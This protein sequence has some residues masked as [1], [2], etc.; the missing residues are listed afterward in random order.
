MGTV[1]RTPRRKYHGL[2]TV[3]E[4]RVGPP[5][6]VIA[7]VGE[8]VV[9]DGGAYVLHSLRLGEKQ[10]PDGGRHLAGFDASP[11]WLYELDGLEV[12]RRVV[13]H[14]DVDGVEV[15]YR[16]RGS[17]GPV[18]LALRPLLRMRPLHDL[19]VANPFLDGELRAAGDH[20]VL[21]LYRD[22][23]PVY[24]SLRGH[25]AELVRDGAWIEGVTYAQEKARGYPFREDLYAPGEY[26]VQ[27]DGPAEL[28]LWI[29]T[30]PRPTAVPV[31]PSPPPEDFVAALDRAAE[32]YT[33]R[34]HT[35]GPTVIAGYPWFGEWSRDALISLPGL[36]LARGRV[37]EATELLE[38]MGS[39]RVD[40]LIPN[41]PGTEA[42]AANRDS[43]DASVLYVHALR[44]VREAA[45][46][47][48]DASLAGRAR[49]LLPIA[50]EI[51]EALADGA[52]RRV[53]LSVDGGLFVERGGWA[54]TWMDAVVDGVPVTPRAGFAVDLDALWLEGLATVLPYAR[55]HL[56][57][58]ASRFGPVLDR[59]IE[60][61][62]PRFWLEEEGYLADCHDGHGP[63]RSLR[64]NQCWALASQLP[65]LS[66][67]RSVRALTAIRR[68]LLTPVGLRTLSADDPSYV[69][70]YEGDQRTRDR[71]YHQGTV[72]PWLL[73]PYADA[74]VAVH[75]LD[76][77]RDEL[78]PALARLE[79]HLFDE[80]CIGQASEIFDADAPHAPRGAPAQAWSVAELLRI[81]RMLSP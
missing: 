31:A 30:T 80:A 19:T 67:E 79:Q 25:D 74:L 6:N 61:F 35:L 8:W 51:L 2:L 65:L 46:H 42:H 63:D 27:L 66:R 71:S 48:G 13:L 69:P 32:V 21:Q 5:L 16:V 68:R 58:F 75:G 24:L 72:W 56:P 12:E 26:R 55:E 73:G 70:R 3:R 34:L 62:A 39:R 40:G 53:H 64:P 38:A 9:H 20:A 1:D 10:D 17:V 37:E 59:G 52:D 33:I 43:V 36:Y 54:M 45:A 47:A 23:P 4:T 81:G 28:G 18:Q 11:R 44:L 57:G 76:R 49:D 41:I 50:C 22:V 77:A 78:A 29:G 7:D 60:A 14:P 15:R